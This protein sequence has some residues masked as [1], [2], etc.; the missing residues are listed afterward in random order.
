MGNDLIDILSNPP[1]S[2]E[3]SAAFDPSLGPAPSLSGIW[4]DTIAAFTPSWFNLGTAAVLGLA[5]LLFIKRR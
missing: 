1:P 3:G 4:N 5:L 2:D